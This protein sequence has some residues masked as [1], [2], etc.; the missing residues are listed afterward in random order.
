[1]GSLL[2]SLIF[3]VWTVIINLDHLDSVF[4]TWIPEP[5]KLFGG[6]DICMG[7]TTFFLA[8][9]NLSNFVSNHIGQVFSGLLHV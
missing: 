4:A 3:F 6:S 8:H 7:Q 1:M 2:S 5:Y 9:I